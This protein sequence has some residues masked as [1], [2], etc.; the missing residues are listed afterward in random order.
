MKK[1]IT[2]DE[3]S[4]TASEAPSDVDHMLGKI[5]Q[6][7]NREC[8]KRELKTSFMIPR[9]QLDIANGRVKEALEANGYTVVVQKYEKVA[10]IMDHIG[11][12]LIGW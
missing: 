2:A 4:M 8:K 5:Y 3:A 9:G 6:K 12:M 10:P 1:C 11:V 7:I